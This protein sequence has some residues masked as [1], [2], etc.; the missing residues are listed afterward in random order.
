MR[1]PPSV[2]A[3]LQR[4]GRA[5]HA[6]GETSVGTL[7]PTH[8][9]DFLEAAVL[10]DAVHDRDIEPQQLMRAPLDVLL[11]RLVDHEKT[12][13]GLLDDSRENLTP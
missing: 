11:E 5:G 3:T 13:P 2:A 4:I 1:S 10:A 12:R 9:Q 6:V 7:F 8:A